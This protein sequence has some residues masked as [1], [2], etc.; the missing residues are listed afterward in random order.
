MVVSSLTSKKTCRANTLGRIMD[1]PNEAR[2]EDD[3]PQCVSTRKPL[4]FL[5]VLGVAAVSL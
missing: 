1:A 2:Q 4:R 3:F 5:C